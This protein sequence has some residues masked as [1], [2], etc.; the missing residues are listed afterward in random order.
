M[1]VPVCTR[2]DLYSLET[3]PYTEYARA[4]SSTFG[5]VR[6]KNLVARPWSCVHVL[7]RVHLGLYSRE[8]WLDFHGRVC[9]IPL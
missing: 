1:H 6:P 9:T 7:V 3:W 8:T 2:L 4:C 5:P